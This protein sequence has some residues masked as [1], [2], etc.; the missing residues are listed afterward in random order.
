MRRAAGGASIGT[1]VA[2]F[3]TALVSVSTPL[4]G[5]PRLEMEGG[6][7]VLRSLPPILADEEVRSHL[8]TGLTTTLALRLEARASTGR[9]EGGAV[10][11]IRFDLWDE[12]FH[13]AAVGAASPP[14]RLRFQSYE[15]LET[16]WHGLDLE[17]LPATSANNTLTQ[18]RLV[19]DVVPFSAAEAQDTQRWF[20]KTLDDAKTSGVDDASA[21]Q[22]SDALSRTFRLMMATSIQRRAIRVFRYE[23][24]I[25][26]SA[27][28]PP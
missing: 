24:E 21:Q 19:I 11:T 25:V 26:R 17:V 22:T 8:E 2:L 20:S 23:P 6:V 5:L 1:V 9:V 16:W 18:A 12:V 7:L 10:V 4:A 3:W 13:A 15:D 28:E 14:R 27:E